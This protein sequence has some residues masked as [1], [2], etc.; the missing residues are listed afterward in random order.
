[1]TNN[2]AYITAMLL[3][4]T[5]HINDFFCIDSHYLITTLE[6]DDFFF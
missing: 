4:L 6:V 2:F 5:E 1:M 3:F